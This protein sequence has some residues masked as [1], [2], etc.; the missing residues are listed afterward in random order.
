MKITRRQIRRIILEALES[1]SRPTPP[2]KEFVSG[3]DRLEGYI[4]VRDS[5]DRNLIA[6]APITST[7]GPD[8]PFLVRTTDTRWHV[9]FGIVR[10][11]YPTVEDV[12][13]WVDSKEDWNNLGPGDHGEVG[14]FEWE[15]VINVPEEIV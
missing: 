4:V 7:D 14:L 10:V 5:H 15:W 3:P 11:I 1:D 6:S 2:E 12:F 13:N 8:R 9:P